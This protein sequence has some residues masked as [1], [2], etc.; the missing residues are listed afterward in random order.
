MVRP[1]PRALCSESE[2][3][4]SNYDEKA[5]RS[6]LCSQIADAKS[7]SNLHLPHG[8]RWFLHSAQSNPAAVRIDTDG[9]FRRGQKRIYAIDDHSVERIIFGNGENSGKKRGS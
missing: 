9:A 2:E 4:V 5:S 7:R 3:E 6:S 8:Q 1:S